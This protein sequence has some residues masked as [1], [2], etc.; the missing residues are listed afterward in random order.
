M[1]RRFVLQV[2]KV[3]ILISIFTFPTHWSVTEIMQ[4]TVPAHLVSIY[5]L[6]QCA[7]PHGL[8]EQEYIPLLSILYK[9]MS[10]RALAQVIAEFV[11]KEYPVVLNDVYRVG[12]AETSPSGVE[13][14]LSSVEQKLTH[15]NYEKWLIEG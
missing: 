5:Q 15:C 12:A 8:E 10:D 14:I 1:Q 3:L 4:K 2:P 13:E 7:F 6:L 11:D 9:K